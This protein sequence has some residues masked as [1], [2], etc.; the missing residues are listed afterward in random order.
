VAGVTVNHPGSSPDGYE[1]LTVAPDGKHV[2][3]TVMNGS[4]KPPGSAFRSDHGLAPV[5]AVKNGKF[6]KVTEAKV[7]RWCQGAA[8]VLSPHFSPI[9][10]ASGLRIGES[11]SATK[12]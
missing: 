6:H 4:N 7:G 12:T 1:S 3:V 5:Y 10:G 2:V 8:W 9:G 11:S